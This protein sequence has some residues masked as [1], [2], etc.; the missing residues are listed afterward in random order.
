MLGMLLSGIAWAG[1]L[2]LWPIALVVFVV[3]LEIR[4]RV[5]DSLLRELFGAEFTAWSREVPAY[6]PFVR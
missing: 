2:P 1:T 4:V 6:F 5:E 3:G